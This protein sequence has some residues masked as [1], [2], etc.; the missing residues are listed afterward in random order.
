MLRR[1]GDTFLFGTA[2]GYSSNAEREGET[3]SQ[4]RHRRQQ[5]QQRGFP[6]LLRTTPWELGQDRKWPVF[7]RVKRGSFDDR[8][9][10]TREGRQRQRE[11]LRHRLADID[12]V[13]VER[14]ERRIIITGEG[15]Y[16]GFQR[17]VS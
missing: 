15:R 10:G 11:F 7:R 6:A 5:P 13:A 1:D 4:N 14:L 16:F 17:T 8:V 9:R 2:M 12:R 3:S